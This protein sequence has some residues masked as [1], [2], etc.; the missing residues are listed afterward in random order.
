MAHVLDEPP[1]ALSRSIVYV[2][3]DDDS[4]RHALSSLFRSTGMHAESFAS[5]DAFLQFERPEVPSCL[6]LD[7]RLRGYS[8]LVFQ[9]QEAQRRDPVPI[10]FMTAHGDVWMCAKAMKAGAVDFLTKPLR[11]QEVLDAVAA[12]IERD[13]AR[14][15]S[16]E[17][18]AD[19]QRRYATLTPREREVLS[20]VL[21]GS[22]N[23]QIAADLALSEVTVKMHRGQVMHKMGSRSVADLVQKAGL[24]GLAPLR[25]N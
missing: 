4:Q 13:A 20:H 10:V 18:N 22:L 17:L 2:I 16:V 23:K 6:L 25:W 5:C 21:R 12:G 3:D 24:L 19:L 11:D 9:T 7:V 15:Q 1:P 8:G 14:R